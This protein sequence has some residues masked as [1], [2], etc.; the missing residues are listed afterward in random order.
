MTKLA[1]PPGQ[2]LVKRM[3]TR[4]KGLII[5]PLGLLLFSAGLCVLSVAAEANHSGAPFRQWFLWG[6]YS[7]IL[8]NSGLLLFGQAVRYRA[9]LDYRRFVRRELK[10][11]DRELTRILQKRKTSPTKGEVK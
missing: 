7:L 2:R 6:A 4:T 8:I 3:S 10:K 5:A 9:Q 1:K 11:R